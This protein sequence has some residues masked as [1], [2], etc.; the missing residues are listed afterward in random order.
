[1]IS[2]SILPSQTRIE[3]NQ[4]SMIAIALF[5]PILPWTKM[6]SDNVF[7]LHPSFASEERESQISMLRS[8]A[9]EGKFKPPL[10]K[11]RETFLDI[12][13]GAFMP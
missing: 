8:R 2:L 5:I 10:A 1:M 13:F 7:S 3:R 4:I 12:C 6:K 11:A 9:R